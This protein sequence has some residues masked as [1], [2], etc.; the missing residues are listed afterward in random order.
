MFSLA[1][2]RTWLDKDTLVSTVSHVTSFTVTC[3]F[4]IIWL[5]S[6]E[7]FGHLARYTHIKE[8][9]KESMYLQ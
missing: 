9:L 2:L 7:I 6:A 5:Y 4:N 8:L 1:A 3:S